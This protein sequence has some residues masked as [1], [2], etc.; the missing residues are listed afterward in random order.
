MRLSRSSSRSRTGVSN[1]QRAAF[2][3][4]DFVLERNV[5]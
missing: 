2:V 1:E 4:A 5:A 3:K